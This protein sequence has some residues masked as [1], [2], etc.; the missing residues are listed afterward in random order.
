MI[1]GKSRTSVVVVDVDEDAI[2][3]VDEDNFSTYGKKIKS[4]DYV[5]DLDENG[6]I[7]DSIKL[8]LQRRKLNAKKSTSAKRKSPK[9]KTSVKRKS[10]KS[11]EMKSAKRSKSP[12][13]RASVK[14]KSSTSS[15]LKLAQRSKS[16]KKKAS[17]KRKSPKRQSPK[18]VSTR[19]RCPNG[20]RRNAKTGRCKKI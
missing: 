7:E 2:F 18:R 9:Q 4:A 16:P 19:K 20:Q 6:E 5:I 8:T 13:K 10:T 3:L 1:D 14:R 12:K 15:K 17:A 11:T